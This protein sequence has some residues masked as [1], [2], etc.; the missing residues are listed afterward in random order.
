[1][2]SFRQDIHETYLGLSESIG[3]KWGDFVQFLQETWPLLLLLLFILLGFWWYADP[4][5]PK[6]VMLATGSKGGFNE[7]LGQKSLIHPPLVMPVPEKSIIES[8]EEMMF[9]IRHEATQII[10][11]ADL[12]VWESAMNKVVSKAMRF[13]HMPN[14]LPRIPWIAAL[15]GPPLRQIPQAG[16]DRRFVNGNPVGNV[17]SERVDNDADI[18]QKIFNGLGICPGMD[19]VNPDRIGEVV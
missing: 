17:G 10:C 16:F 13:R 1:M 2:G 19:V 14:R 3:E 11:R 9:S 6:H 8:I 7:I 15:W 18:A 12:G 4:P 5:P